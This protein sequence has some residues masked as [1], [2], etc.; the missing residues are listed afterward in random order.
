VFISKFLDT[1][2]QFLKNEAKAFV[3]EHVLYESLE[4]KY[5]LYRTRVYFKNAKIGSNLPAALQIH[6]FSNNIGPR[7]FRPS[8]KFRKLQTLSNSVYF[9]H[10]IHMGTLNYLSTNRLHSGETLCDPLLL[11]Y[12]YNAETKYWFLGSDSPWICSG[13]QIPWY[14][15]FKRISFRPVSAIRSL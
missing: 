13:I 12:F 10:L 3:T 2:T 5:N 7:A 6:Y 4:I 15:W 1:Q 14:V 11:F 8:L 9:P